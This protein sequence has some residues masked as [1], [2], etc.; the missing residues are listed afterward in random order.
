MN[1]HRDDITLSVFV[2]FFVFLYLA[3]QQLSKYHLYGFAIGI[4]V[5][6]IIINFIDGL[7]YQLL[8]CVLLYF[9]MR[10][11]GKIYCENQKK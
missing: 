8:A 7:E 10:W 4:L 9:I 1:D 2:L 3:T 5:G 11:V 6:I